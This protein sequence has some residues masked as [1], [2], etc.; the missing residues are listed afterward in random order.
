MDCLRGQLCLIPII[1]K[2]SISF[3]GQNTKHSIAHF[4][5]FSSTKP[6]DDNSQALK[7]SLFDIGRVSKNIQIAHPIFF[8][9]YIAETLILFK[10]HQRN[11][12]CIIG[13][14]G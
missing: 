5:H 11:Q 7:H 1:N 6:V 4:Q 10:E 12:K 9:I 3:S 14:Y 2:R 13:L 8:Q